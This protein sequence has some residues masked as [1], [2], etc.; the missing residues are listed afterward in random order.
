MAS[1]A[2]KNGKPGDFLLIRT[3]HFVSKLIRFGQRDYGPE[4]QVWNHVALIVGDDQIVEALTGGVVLSPRSKYLAS[5]TRLVVSLIHGASPGL[6]MVVETQS[7][8]DMRAN[9][10]AFARSCVGESY[11]WATIAAIA[12][13]VLTK[14]RVDFGISGTSICSG[15]VARSLERLGYIFSPYDP[16]ELTPAYLAKTLGNNPR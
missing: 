10:V 1:E 6:P 7:G 3:N 9:A 8:V 15:L 13:K 11:G 16:A 5:D 14:G 2:Q 12:V 4:A